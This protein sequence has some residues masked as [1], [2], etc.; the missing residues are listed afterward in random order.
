MQSQPEM[1]MGSGLRAQN[2]IQSA[3]NPFGSTDGS[4][5]RAQ[6]ADDA[7]AQALFRKISS[8][9]LMQPS[10]HSNYPNEFDKYY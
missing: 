3:G 1:A 8:Q 4:Y 9:G 7:H 2:H 6:Q 5:V 10:H